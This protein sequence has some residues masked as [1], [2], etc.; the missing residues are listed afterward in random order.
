MVC[1]GKLYGKVFDRKVRSGNNE[2]V[3]LGKDTGT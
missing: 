3:A 1:N 2:Y